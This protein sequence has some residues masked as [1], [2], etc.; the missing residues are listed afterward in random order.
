[1]YKDASGLGLKKEISTMQMVL[2]SKNSD[3]VTTCINATTK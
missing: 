1:M 2:M 3:I